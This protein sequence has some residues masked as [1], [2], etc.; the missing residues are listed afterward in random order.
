MAR[1]IS[2]KSTKQARSAQS[3]GGRAPRSRGAKA[4]GMRSSILALQQTAGNRAISQ[5]LETAG[6][7]T[8]SP[9]R[10]TLMSEG[11]PLDPNLRSLM[12]SRFGRNLEQ[13]RIHTGPRAAESADALDSKAFSIGREVIFGKG[14]YAPDTVEGKQLLAHELAHVLQQ[15]GGTEASAAPDKGPAES[16]SEREADRVSQN[17]ADTTSIPAA[18]VQLSAAPVGI[19]RKPKRLSAA[20]LKEKSKDPNF[21]QKLGAA[22]ASEKKRTSAKATELRGQYNA[23]AAK[24]PPDQGD[25]SA[26]GLDKPHKQVERTDTPMS[27]GDVKQAIMDA[28]RKTF[29]TRIPAKVLGLLVAKWYA[30]GGTSQ[31]GIHNFNLGN[32]E[33]ELGD[34]DHPKTPNSDYTR[35]NADEYSKGERVSPYAAYDSPEQG[36]MGLIHFISQRP[37][38]KAALMSGKPEDYVYVAKSHNYFEAPVEDIEVDG[39]VARAGYL[40]A[41]KDNVPK[42]EKLTET[43]TKADILDAERQRL[44]S[45]AKEL[46]GK[47]R[48]GQIDAEEYEKRYRAFWDSWN[49]WSSKVDALQKALPTLDKD[50][51]PDMLSAV[52]KGRKRATQLIEGGRS[53]DFRKFAALLPSP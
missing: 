50:I 14:N 1:S 45:Q 28:W 41:V 2:T 42:P 5:A 26:L 32:T 20:E 38:L 51:E 46:G 37:A 10:E 9:L 47:K 52:E 48:G 4:A 44:A 19:H 33:V 22:K 35:Y 30:E 8:P 24:Q 17:V 15:A 25:Y 12:E 27:E 31:R 34:K 23:E 39:E 18:P 36:A 13:V 43:G 11:Q 3:E 21:V 40:P 6:S 53:D 7:R 49:Q 16:Q 29:G